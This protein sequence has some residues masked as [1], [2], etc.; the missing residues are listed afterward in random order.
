[1]DSPSA[2][3]IEA[4][5]EGDSILAPRLETAPDLLYNLGFCL[6]VSS[7]R[8]VAR[9]VLP[10]TAPAG[11][12]L[13]T[14]LIRIANEGSNAF[15][16]A[17]KDLLNISNSS[18]ELCQNGG[19]LDQLGDLLLR[20]GT[21]SSKKLVYSWVQDCVDSCS[22][23]GNRTASNF[24]SW[25]ST[26]QQVSETVDAAKNANVANIENTQR[27][28]KLTEHKVKVNDIETSAAVEEVIFAIRRQEE[29]EKVYAKRTGDHESRLSEQVREYDH[30]PF[31]AAVKRPFKGAANK[32]ALHETQNLREEAEDE[33]QEAVREMN[34]RRKAE[35]ALKLKAERLS[36]QIEEYKGEEA[37]LSEI[38]DIISLVCELLGE[39][40]ADVSALLHKFATLSED[41][42]RLVEIKMRV[43]KPAGINLGFARVNPFSKKA[44]LREASKRDE[45]LQNR[46]FAQQIRR[47][48]Q[49]CLGIHVLSNLY[50]GVINDVINYGFAEA[51]RASYDDLGQSSTKMIVAMRKKKMKQWH[52]QAKRVCSQRNIEA[53]RHFNARVQ[54]MGHGADGMGMGVPGLPM[55]PGSMNMAGFG[56][57]SMGGF[58]QLGVAA[59]G[60]GV[61]QPA[62]P[63][64]VGVEPLS[65]RVVISSPTTGRAREAFEL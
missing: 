36:A 61:R 9:I 47:M 28:K 50:A 8:D 40:A 7:T 25:R 55:G 13:S 22:A 32:T 63:H 65:G 29:K 46:L 14:N 54:A 41:I 34:Q 33:L 39:L 26:V 57:T 15:L 6:A 16:G 3:D 18:E 43:E 24:D 62:G 4:S 64:E 27:M 58:S 5:R 49:V 30:N 48:K 37:K 21:K 53:A 12:A 44:T 42:K 45:A 31:W 20:D 38:V 1:M 23:A 56:G 19:L 51:L 35:L 17:Y 52:D 60:F 59:G 2:V 11:P 10:S